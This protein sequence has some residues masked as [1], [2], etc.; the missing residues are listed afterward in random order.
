MPPL[1]ICVW[2]DHINFQRPLRSSSAV[3]SRILASRFIP[4][5]YQWYLLTVLNV[6]NPYGQRD[7]TSWK[8]HK[9]KP[10]EETRGELSTQR[11]ELRRGR[12]GKVGQQKFDWCMMHGSIRRCGPMRTLREWCQR[13]Q[14]G[15]HPEQYKRDNSYLRVYPVRSNSGWRK[16]IRKTQIWLWS[17]SAVT[18]VRWYE[19]ESH[20]LNDCMYDNNP[21]SDHCPYFKLKFKEPDVRHINIAQVTVVRAPSYAL[22]GPG[23]FPVSSS[24]LMNVWERGR[25]I[26]ASRRSSGEPT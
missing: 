9:V 12:L 15:A 11:W 17:S 21:R 18:S 19:L 6:L 1:A 22:N 26:N 7:H 3:T 14:S 13:D 16:S 2:E 5:E 25:S 23:N 8:I 10:V 24:K 20:D 4:C